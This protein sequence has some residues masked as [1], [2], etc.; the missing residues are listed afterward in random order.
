MVPTFFSVIFAHNLGSFDAIKLESNP[1][2]PINKDSTNFLLNILPLFTPTTTT[3]HKK[4]NNVL[5]TKISFF[6][7]STDSSSKGPNGEFNKF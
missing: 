5:N 3:K 1:S 2:P 7:T 6:S 4:T